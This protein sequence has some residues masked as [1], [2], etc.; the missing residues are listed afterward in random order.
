MSHCHDEHCEH[1]HSDLPDSGEQFLLYSK[2]DLDNVRCLNESE[3][4]SGKK[5]IRPWNERMD[6]LKLVESDADEQLIVVIPF[7]GSVKLRSICLRT[8]PTDSAP[9]KMK[10]FINRDDVDFDTA[11]SYTPVQEFD[12]VEG[13]NNVIEYGVRITKFTSVRNIILYFPE[14]FGED[15]S[16][17]R[18]IG[19]K[20]EW[21][22][23]KRDPIITI[24]EAKANPADHKVP[25]AEETMGH[26]I[27]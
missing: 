22:E 17:I 9:S 15:T 25:G 21:T 26:S 24:Y 7:T 27:Q 23:I 12:L 14:N 1:D 4:N 8:D 10:V 11:D 5:V 16:I 19:F 3:P 13:S 6:D 18:Y 20:G 2:I